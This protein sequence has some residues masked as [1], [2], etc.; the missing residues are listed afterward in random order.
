ML[1]LTNQFAIMEKSPNKQ[2]A[3][4]FIRTFFD[5]DGYG[6]TDGIPVTE[7]GLEK[8]MAEALEPPYYIDEAMGGIKTYMSE[9]AHDWTSNKDINITPMTEAD[10]KRYEEFVRSVD[11]ASSGSFDSQIN[12]IISEETSAYFAGNCSA[13]Q[14][15]EMIQ[16]RVSIMLSE[17]S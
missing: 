3:W 14:C 17:Q 10:R 12:K 7:S 4:E 9:T 8:V 5:D 13:Q 1:L 15:A 16:N 11:I 6:Q 2:G